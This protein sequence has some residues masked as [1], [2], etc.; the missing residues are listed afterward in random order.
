L[1]FF[2]HRVKKNLEGVSILP[3]FL[4][5]LGFFG[6]FWVV[7]G[8]FGFLGCWLNFLGDIMGKKDVKS[9][10]KTQT[11]ATTPYVSAVRSRMAEEKQQ[12]EYAKLRESQRQEREAE[13]R[14]K[15]SISEQ[16]YR[17]QYFED[18]FE[19]NLKG[20]IYDAKG[21]QISNFGDFFVA[22]ATMKT[23]TKR[24]NFQPKSNEF[25]KSGIIKDMLVPLVP[26]ESKS[27][28]DKVPWTINTIWHVFNATPI[29]RLGNEITFTTDQETNDVWFNEMKE[30]AK[31]QS[32]GATPTLSRRPSAVAESANVKMEIPSADQM[33]RMLAGTKSRPGKAPVEAPIEPTKSPRKSPV[34][35]AFPPT[36]D[37]NTGIDTRNPTPKKSPAKSPA[38]SPVKPAFPPTL[39][40]NTG[41][42]TRNPTPK[43]SPAPPAKSPAKSTPKTP[44]KPAF[45]PTL[46]PNT[47]I[48]TRLA[49]PGKSPVELLKAKLDQITKE[50]VKEFKD[51]ISKISP[52]V[53]VASPTQ[54]TEI[55]LSRRIL[56]SETPAGIARQKKVEEAKKKM[57]EESPPQ[58]N[59]WSPPKS[60]SPMQVDTS[61]PKSAS[62][63]PKSP[64]KD[65]IVPFKDFTPTRAEGKSP[66]PVTLPKPK[67]PVK[68]AVESF[69]QYTP[70]KEQEKSPVVQKV[71][72]E[73]TGKK[74][75]TPT[76]Y[77][78]KLYND[79]R[80]HLMDLW[81]KD[82][83][84]YYSTTPRP[85]INSFLEFLN[86]FLALKSDVDDR[87]A[88]Q[89]YNIKKSR[90]LLNEAS[91]LFFHKAFGIRM[92]DIDNEE[93]IVDDDL[94]MDLNPLVLNK[95]S[96]KPHV[97]ERFINH[98]TEITPMQ[99]VRNRNIAAEREAAIEKPPE[100]QPKKPQQINEFEAELAAKQAKKM[101]RARALAEKKAEEER[102]EQQAKEERIR[103][104]AEQQREA[105]R[106]AVRARDQAERD[107][108]EAFLRIPILRRYLYN[109][110]E[111][112]YT[113]V[114]GFD[115]NK[116]I[117]RLPAFEKKEF[118]KIWYNEFAKV[119]YH[120]KYDVKRDNLG[121]NYSTLNIN[122]SEE[123][124][125]YFV[126]IYS[127]VFQEINEKYDVSNT[128]KVYNI[129]KLDLDIIK[130]INQDIANQSQE[131]F[132]TQDEDDSSDVKDTTIQGESFEEELNIT[133]NYAFD[134]EYDINTYFDDD[135]KKIINMIHNP[136]TSYLD[137]FVNDENNQ[138]AMKKMSYDLNIRVKRL[139]EDYT[140]NWY[141]KIN[142]NNYKIGK[143]ITF[144]LDKNNTIIFL[145]AYAILCSQLSSDYDD[146]NQTIKLW[147]LAIKNYNQKINQI[148]DSV[149]PSEFDLKQTAVNESINELTPIQKRQSNQVIRQTAPI[150]QNKYLYIIWLDN[151]KTRYIGI[152]K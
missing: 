17:Q 66:K 133:S 151:Q 51:E 137:V 75:Y 42:D 15:K 63:K 78:S 100:V 64:V 32:R 30:L 127:K 9:L 12:D 130:E 110:K 26:E 11:T 1:Y 102:L 114:T 88:T 125:N 103:R 65:T 41:I 28:F 84:R 77:K 120:L 122:K 53:K 16:D 148:Y 93:D 57:A 59:I 50:K 36:L 46:D 123:D 119:L 73:L 19:R 48:D 113:F 124:F 43:K 86:S 118:Q 76:V 131:R 10:K 60:D 83:T 80:Q 111:D 149:Q 128:N 140:Y 29:K 139:I 62:T 40:P 97:I 99:K 6:F 20:N 3:F 115:I 79:Y 89:K 25:L 147:L 31:Q 13:E 95:D 121:W 85:S 23:S 61:P 68:D 47:G 14:L 129:S 90:F 35:P 91:Q 98:L 7:L 134:L 82:A 112:S 132:N 4:E 37:P 117:K 18:Y 8:C 22:L 116:Q 105:E 146:I 44:V 108:R 39:D 136:N 24:L 81:I 92:P 74:E 27:A 142:P 56:E 55:P 70:T 141:K 144:N 135:E 38:K 45:P 145:K 2:F 94:V 69:K 101:E 143:S 96:L 49:T 72:A 152:T 34:K 109:E 58:T 33:S 104:M 5:I 71:V 106:E 126:N 21:G 107:E 54:Q 52:Q 150:N 138:R 87:V 67:S